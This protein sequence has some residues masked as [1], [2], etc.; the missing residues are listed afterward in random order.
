MTRI[1]LVVA[2]VTGTIS[3]VFNVH[4]AVQALFYLSLLD[5]GSGLL[6][7]FITST[8]SSDASIKGMSKK[9]FMFLM[10]ATA[11]VAEKMTGI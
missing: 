11:Y 2:L 4:P 1:T 6:K 7:G 10:V 5:I 9:V 3:G 8:L